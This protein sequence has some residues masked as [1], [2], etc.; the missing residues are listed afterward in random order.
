MIDEQCQRN[1]R[2]IE[3]FLFRMSMLGEGVPLGAAFEV[4]VGEIKEK[5]LALRREEL[6]VRLEECWLDGALGTKELI[7]DLIDLFLE[8]LG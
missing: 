4:G 2:A 3:A 7:G 5:E 6:G 1:K 8:E